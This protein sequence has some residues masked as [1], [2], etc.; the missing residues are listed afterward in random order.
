MR[1]KMNIEE[2]AKKYDEAI[3]PIVCR[4]EA[5]T[6]VSVT[7]I[8][9]TLNIKLPKSIVEF[10][11]RTKNYGNWLA[12]IGPDFDNPSHI[13]N[14]NKELREEGEIPVNFVAI[15]VG[16]DEDYECIDIET[17]NPYIDEYLITYWA[18]DVPLKES[19]L[20]GSFFEMMS[21]NIASWG[22]CA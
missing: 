18:K 14:I 19:G 11:K 9:N 10:A 17:Y 16:Y 8:E 15:N 5:P 13:L 20:Y 2:L 12:S 1:K 3:G 22:K 7:D 6:T 4:A 21:D